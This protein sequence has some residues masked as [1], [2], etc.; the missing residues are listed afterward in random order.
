MTEQWVKIYTDLTARKADL[1]LLILSSQHI[2][3]NIEKQNSRYDIRVR[4][5]QIK[6]ACAMV[7][8][9]YKENKFRITKQQISS[10]NISSF[11]SCTCYCIMALICLIHATAQ[12]LNIH[13][14]LI[15]SCGASGLYILQGETYRAI[16]AL[17]LHSDAR[18]LTGNMAGLLIF[19]APVLSLSGFGTGAFLI[20]F[21]GT[22]GNLLNAWV[23]QT[24]HLSIGASTAIMG[25]AG[26]LSAHQMTR[27][28]RGSVF[29]TLMPLSAGALLVGLFS[30]G[31]NTDIMA[32]FLGFASG[33]FSGLLFLP[34]LRFL[35][36]N[37]KEPIAL[38]IT[39]FIIITA[40]LHAA[41]LISK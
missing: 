30:Q 17:F 29:N 11:K 34:M 24:A 12:Y 41:G 38:F 2:K 22:T 16:T 18:H 9:Y 15:L 27:H 31:E 26:F 13:E 19:C 23:H 4:P 39:I 1:I 35:S 33:F 25:G 28:Q 5:N 37:K 32:H 20:L 8:A 14:S 6:F 3:T 40:F 10:L 7:N 36:F 21:A